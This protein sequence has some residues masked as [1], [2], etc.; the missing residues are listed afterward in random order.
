MPFVHLNA[1]ILIGVR[2][3][4]LDQICVVKRTGVDSFARFPIILNGLPS[5]VPE[6]VEKAA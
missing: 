5:V 6:L 1:V 2:V 4:S 3:T